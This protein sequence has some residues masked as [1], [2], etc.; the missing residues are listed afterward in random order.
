MPIEWAAHRA[1]LPLAAS[2]NQVALALP[3]TAPLICRDPDAGLWVLEVVNH[4]NASAVSD[5]TF[6][7]NR[8]AWPG[9]MRT[10]QQ[11]GI[12]LHCRLYGGRA[13][14]KLLI[15]MTGPP[16]VTHTKL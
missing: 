14:T 8:E 7:T 1:K 12:A 2:R 6:D 15:Q 3:S 11:E 5:G 4:E 9:V 16:C 13:V 10:I